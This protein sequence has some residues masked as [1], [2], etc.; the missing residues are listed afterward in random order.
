LVS[1]NPYGRGS[2]LAWVFVHDLGSIAGGTD[3]PQR[4]RSWIDEL[5]LGK[6]IAGALLGLGLEEGSAW[7]AVGL[8]KILTEHQGWFD[9]LRGESAEAYQ[10]LERLLADNDVQQFLQVHRHEGILWF[11]KE[12]FDELLA[13]LLAVAVVDARASA[14]DPRSA[15]KRIRVR[16]DLIHRLQSA[17]ESSG[18]RVEQLLAGAAPGAVGRT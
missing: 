4:S 2:L 16:R 3:S 12:S 14:P 15:A 11:N 8:V 18:Y 7:R 17:E 9:G 6:L 10:V 1:E 13:G 5:L